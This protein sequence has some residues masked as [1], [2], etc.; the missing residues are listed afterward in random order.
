MNGAICQLII[1]ISTKVY[2]KGSIGYN[3]VYPE[4]I[5]TIPDKA[6]RIVNKIFLNISK[7]KKKAFSKSKRFFACV[8]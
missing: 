3:L 1:P 6:Q 5:N 4:K 2:S 8:I 7:G